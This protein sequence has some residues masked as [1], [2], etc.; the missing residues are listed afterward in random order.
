MG[1]IHRDIKPDNIV[2]D[3]RGHCRLADFGSCIK[4]DQLAR[5][6]QCMVA[7]GTPDYL[8]FDASVIFI[9]YI[10]IFSHLFFI[11]NTD[12]ELFFGFSLQSMEGTKNIQKRSSSL[13]NDL[14]PPY[15]YEIDFWSCKC[16]FIL[17]DHLNCSNCF[18]SHLHCTD[19][20]SG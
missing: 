16:F 18:F 11:I 2:L 7:V 14:G 4:S 9:F 3:S 15:S 20:N 19:Q 5:D 10:F 6:G 1:Y 12:F 17:F 13:T 8:C